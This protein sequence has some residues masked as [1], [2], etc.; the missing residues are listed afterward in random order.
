MENMV[1]IASQLTDES[2]EAPKIDIAHIYLQAVG[3]E[4]KKRRV[5]GLGTHAST[6]FQD[7]V[8]SSSSASSHYN[9]LFD[10]RLR[11]ELQEIQENL[12]RKK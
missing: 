7:F 11:E 6:F 5:Y 2:T 4:S 9:I 8:L 1:A 12:H 10:E 3:V